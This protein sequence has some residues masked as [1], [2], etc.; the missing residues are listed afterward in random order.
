MNNS[1]FRYAATFH[2]ESDGG[3]VVHFP[4]FTYG[5]TQG[6]SL[7]ESL[8]MAQDLLICLIEDYIDRG[9]ALPRPKN[10]RSPRARWVVLPLL[11]QAKLRLRQ[12]LRRSG[13]RPQALARKLRVGAAEL[14]AILDIGVPTPIE[15][16]E[17]AFRALDKRLSVVVVDAA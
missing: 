9:V 11:T 4:D 7:P 17:A 12:A 16:V 15:T 14:D 8:D 1:G 10:R 13:M 5:V 2:R 3:Y 6:D